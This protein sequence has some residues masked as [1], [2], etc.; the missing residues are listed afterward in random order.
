MVDGQPTGPPPPARLPNENVFAYHAR[1]RA[2]SWVG[3]SGTACVSV[4]VPS[5]DR[6]S[7]R[8]GSVRRMA[9]QPSGQSTTRSDERTAPTISLDSTA[10]PPASRDCATRTGAIR[11]RAIRSVLRDARSIR[12]R[13]AESTM[14][15]DRGGRS[16]ENAMKRG[17]ASRM[18]PRVAMICESSGGT[19]PRMPSCW[20]SNQRRCD[21]TVASV[22]SPPSAYSI[23]V[24]AY[25]PGPCPR[26]PTCLTVLA[27][28][29]SRI[30]RRSS[31]SETSTRPSERILAEVIPLNPE[32]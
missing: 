13:S 20:R 24:I 28:M 23:G 1:C 29:S 12:Y 10:R 15:S 22:V 6:Q 11:S 31:N 9:I 30:R 18:L 25:S 26:R 2:S 17:L 27:R 7:I 14:P 4:T 32:S 16:C 8:A 19:M 21:R 3:G 5:G